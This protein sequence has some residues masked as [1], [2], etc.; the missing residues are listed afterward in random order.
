M[1]VAEKQRESGEK[2]QLMRN[3]DMEAVYRSSLSDASP[4][5]LRRI[6]DTRTLR[7]RACDFWVRS[8]LAVCNSE[9]D[10]RLLGTSERRFRGSCA[11]L[12]VSAK[13]SLDFSRMLRLVIQRKA[14]PAIDE[15]AAED[16]RTID[17]LLN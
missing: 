11:V 4:R 14:S 17:R 16:V 6:M 10:T 7:G 8:V 13:A 5:R 12:S 1:T 15:L 2:Q 3:P 9:T